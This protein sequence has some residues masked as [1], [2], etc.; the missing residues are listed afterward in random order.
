MN[1]FSS[2]DQSVNIKISLEDEN[3][4]MINK[5]VQAAPSWYNGQQVS[6]IVI[7]DKSLKDKIR[8]YF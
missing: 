8:D 7:K 2:I 6:I 5:A 3:P 1:L 4:Q